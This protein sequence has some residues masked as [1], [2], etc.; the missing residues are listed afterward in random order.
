MLFLLNKLDNKAIP[1]QIGI[2]EEEQGGLALEIHQYILSAILEVLTK[3]S[4]MSKQHAVSGCW[5]LIYY[6]VTWN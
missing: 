6:S 4:E 2:E 5:V 1:G 3:S